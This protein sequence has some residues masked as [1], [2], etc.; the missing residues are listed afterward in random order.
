[1]YLFIF[2]I[3]N[4][5]L[6]AKCLYYSNQNITLSF[7]YYNINTLFQLQDILTFIILSLKKYINR[8]II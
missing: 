8:K 3:E 1:M 7:L 6:N 4:V 5:L 2:T